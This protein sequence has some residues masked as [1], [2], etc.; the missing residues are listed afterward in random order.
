MFEQIIQRLKPKMQEV[1][2]GL[3]DDLK[4]IRTGKANPALVEQIFVSYYGSKMPLKQLAN[5]SVPDPNLI[6]IQPWDVNSLGDIEM[7]IR[8]SE[9]NLTPT[10]DGRVIRLSLPPLT[11]ER[12]QEVIKLVHQKAE[13]TRVMLRNLREDSW[14]EIQQME[15]IGKLTEDDR[16]RGEKE[17]NDLIKEYNQ[18]IQEVIN[19]KEKEIKTI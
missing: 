9:L 16:Y 11:A 5:V 18:K 1:I 17:L 19:N 7:A 6:V 8:N 13:G 4:T 14:R 2:S 15:K 10:N 12:R 3:E